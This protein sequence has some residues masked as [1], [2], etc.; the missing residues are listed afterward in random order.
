MKFK[1]AKITAIVLAVLLFIGVPTALVVNS[2]IVSADNRNNNNVK[3]CPDE[4]VIDISEDEKPVADEQMDFSGRLNPDD[5]GELNFSLSD[6]LT[7]DGMN[8]IVNPRNWGISEIFDENGNIRNDG[9]VTWSFKENEEAYRGFESQI[10]EQ[11]NYPHLPT[12]T[13][14]EWAQIKADIEN[15]VIKPFNPTD[16][17][18]GAEIFFFDGE[19][20]YRIG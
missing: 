15:G 9:E 18:K 14:E 2:L 19:N 5:E 1:K 8:I 11:E 13:D 6:A 7:I 4:I 3:V 20:L 10:A 12:Y 16:I 17:P